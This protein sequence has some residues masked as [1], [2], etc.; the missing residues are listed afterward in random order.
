MKLLV[1]FFKYLGKIFGFIRSALLNLILLF[2][3]VIFIAAISS[4][5]LPQLPDNDALLIHPKGILVDEL[6]FEPSPMDFLSTEQTETE[7]RVRDVIN[8]IN[9]AATDS[10]IN[11]LMLNL[12]H[13]TGGGMSKLGEI[14]QAIEKFK[15]SGKPVVAYAD[16]FTQ[17]QY[18]LA[19][20]ADTIYVNEM[21]SIFLTGYGV[22]R[23]YFKDA[24]DKLHMKFHVFRVGDHKD[25]VEPYLENSMSSASR[26]HN[27]RWLNAL[28]ERYTSQ[29]EQS[30][31]FPDGKIDNFIAT[32]ATEFKDFSATHAQFSASVGLVDASL[33]RPQLREKLVETFGEK[34][35]GERIAAIDMHQYLQLIPDN[36]KFSTNPIGLIV[37]TGT[38]LDGQQLAGSIGGDSLSALIRQ[39]RKDEELK[40]LVIRVDSGG[41]SVFASELIRQEII[42]TRDEGLPVYIS[43]G[44]VAASG[45]YWIAAPADEIWATP[46]TITGS[47]GVWAL[48]PNYSETFTKL[49]I[50]TDGVATTKL[51]GSFRGDLPMN[52][53]VKVILQASVDNVY[54]NFLQITAEAR[55]LETLEVHKIAQGQVWTGEAAKSLGLIDNL[56]SLEDLFASV[57]DKLSLGDYQV[58]EIV[59]PLSNREQIFRALLQMST[60]AT[61]AF[62]E[63][64]FN[65]IV[66]GQHPSGLA[67]E[68]S[69][70]YENINTA[71]QIPEVHKG[72]VI[73]Q[74]LNCIAP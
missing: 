62:Q 44:S 18:Y 71:L 54:K 41:G 56:G 60:H 67:A 40:A 55:Q 38:I 1:K 35:N 17:Q 57:A 20:F 15:L 66:G 3:L 49:G 47:I 65:R 4:T 45:G 52:D 39:A 58:R 31:D 73:S 48:I 70:V 34:E 43:M 33:T 25:A 64:I 69:S 5:P 63:S 50:H 72:D 14:G 22:Y 59:K 11:G 9:A 53:D 37:A 46:E 16:Y 61:Q 7:T 42:T 30:R 32:M 68:I 29:I 24:I 12:N 10:R 74:C 6:S 8:S 21:G 13:M 28:W 19:S 23:N 26:E 51:A 2:F 36:N 27:A